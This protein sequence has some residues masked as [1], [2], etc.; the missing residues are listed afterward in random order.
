MFKTAGLALAI[1]CFPHIQNNIDSDEHLRSKIAENILIIN[2]SVGHKEANR[3]ASYVYTWSK[4]KNINPDVV[5]GIIQVESRFKHTAVGQISNDFGPMQVN[6]Y[7][8]KKLNIT[9]K[10]LLTVEKGI[11]MGVTILDLKRRERVTGGC[12][13][14]IYNARNIE[15]RHKYEMRIN[16][17]VARLGVWFDCAGVKSNDPANFLTWEARNL[18]LS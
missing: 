15:K 12:W 2:P 14:S 1:V 13:W 9:K 10:D 7:W 8:L 4:I 6:E 3:Y 18:L 16:K 5:L 11:M 17:V